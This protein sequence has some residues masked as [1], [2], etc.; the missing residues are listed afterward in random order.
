MHGVEL[1]PDGIFVQL[2]LSGS[3]PSDEYAC[4][5]SCGKRV[6]SGSLRL[7]AA[8]LDGARR[9]ASPMRGTPPASP[10]AFPEAEDVWPADLVP[11]RS[12]SLSPRWHVNN[13]KPHAQ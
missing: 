13:K 9:S 6:Q 3:M 10:R 12:G 1:R 8:E 5:Q 7:A 2:H 4:N 11:D